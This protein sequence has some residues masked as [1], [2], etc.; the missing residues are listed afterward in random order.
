MPSKNLVAVGVAA[1]LGGL[2]LLLR[3]RR[4]ARAAALDEDGVDDPPGPAIRLR[5]GA[6]EPPSTIAPIAEEEE[7][8]AEGAART[9]QTAA[10][11]WEEATRAKERGNKRFTGRQYDQALREY[12]RAISIAPDA[13]DERVS[14]YY[15]NRAACLSMLDDF[16]G[17]VRDCD[18]A[19]QINPKYVKALNRRGSAHEKLDDLDAAL[20]DYTASCLLSCF[21]QQATIEA[22]DRVLK[23]IGQRKAEERS[24]CATKRLPSPNFIR[25][26]M[27]S[28]V[29][30]RRM[31]K[32]LG[33]Q[34]QK[35]AQAA[36]RRE[37]C[38]RA[39]EPAKHAALLEEEAIALMGEQRYD[40]ALVAW[41]AA[42]GAWGEA[43]GA[44]AKPGARDA[45]RAHNMVGTF[46]HVRGSLEEAL[47][48]YG[49]AL[50]LD[51]SDANAL[52]KRASLHFE[53]EQMESCLADFGAAE[54]AA[55]GNDL[56]D[57]CCHRG[58]VYML[59]GQ[60]EEAVAE[61]KRGLALD[62]SV[63]LTHI[64]LAMSHFRLGRREESLRAFSE[65]E[66]LFPK[67][68]EVF[69]FHGELLVEC[70][71]LAEALAKFDQ[72]IRVGGDRLA[73]AYVNKANA[74]AIGRGGPDEE[75]RPRCP[76]A[77]ALAPR[78]CRLPAPE[79]RCCAPFACISAVCAA[80]SLLFRFVNSGHGRGCVRLPPPLSRLPPSAF[81]R[82]PR[83]PLRSPNPLAR[84]SPSSRRRRRSTR[85][86]R[87]RSC[88]WRSSSGSARSWRRRLSCMT[89]PSSC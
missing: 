32:P 74:V 82:S 27:D 47:A 35:A 55:K 21:E 46:Y 50:A 41:E 49:K 10:E 36:A 8:L 43:A 84:S 24:R 3:W 85:S 38:P 12:S 34:P 71:Q 65:A 23:V 83:S 13:T 59:R 58:Q 52:I 70:G 11:C 56:A 66:R 77:A 60:L 87:L 75:V 25:T 51:P 6:T 20:L 7:E 57:V 39:S 5:G 67:C 69:N 81:P 72:A 9:P 64:Q 19:L 2:L 31:L 78:G 54:K 86:P 89:A 79:H 68:A 61:L 15:C 37:A 26:F 42:V 88:T 16:V 76:C 45:R 18:M 17:C 48:E 1:G 53:R 29:S 4:Q 28:F 62:S 22:A 44:G 30:H 33:G 63:M 80:S 14:V 73:A 40:E